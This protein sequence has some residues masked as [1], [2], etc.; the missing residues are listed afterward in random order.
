M[1]RILVV[2]DEPTI[3]QLIT[4]N[5]QQAHYAVTEAADGAQALELALN[6]DFNCIVLDLMLPKIDGIEVTKRLR[7]A[8]VQTPIIMLTAK[9][10]EA[11]KIIGLELG[12]DDYMTKPFSPRELLARI[13]VIGRRGKLKTATADFPQTVH[14][15]PVSW[16]LDQHHLVN[17]EATLSLTKKEYELLKYLVEN[18]GKIVSREQIMASV[19]QTQES[20]MS[21][22]V[23]IQISHL[24]DKIEPDPK[25]A[26]FLQTVRGFGYRLEVS[27]NEK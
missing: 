22:M 3:R 1:A 18:V 13:K 24:R 25:E 8:D 7:S 17:G 4:Y 21:R 9:Q 15:G 19:W 14:F 12:A 26:Q 6:Q 20:V 10:E 5:L 2:D 23:D 11:D 16:Q 27:E